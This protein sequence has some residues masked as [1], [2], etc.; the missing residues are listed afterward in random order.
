MSPI[1]VDEMPTIGEDLGLRKIHL[2]MVELAEWSENRVTAR[3]SYLAV[4][5]YRMK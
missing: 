2:R 4:E 5:T 1:P 3:K